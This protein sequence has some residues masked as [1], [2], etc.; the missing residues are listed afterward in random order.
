MMAIMHIR[1]ERSDWNDVAVEV[2]NSRNFVVLSFDLY[3]L[4][5]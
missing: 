2:I 4:D 1:V 3:K 5:D